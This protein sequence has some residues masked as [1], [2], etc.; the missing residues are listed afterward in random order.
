MVHAH[1]Q[2]DASPIARQHLEDGR[3]I[4]ETGQAAQHRRPALDMALTRCRVGMQLPEVRRIELL[5][6]FDDRPA[7]FAQEGAAPTREC[8]YETPFFLLRSQF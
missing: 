4:A 2:F 1:A 7:I 5:H 6:L 8:G 3:T